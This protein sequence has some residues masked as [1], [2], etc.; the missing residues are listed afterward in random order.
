VR[1]QVL[2]QVMIANLNDVAQSWALGPDGGYRRLKAGQH[3][4]RAHDY[5][6][7]N[8]SLSGRGRALKRSQAVPRL[9]RNNV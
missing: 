9:V 1:Q 7:N 6:M 2:E 4:F 5:F 8:P 3:A